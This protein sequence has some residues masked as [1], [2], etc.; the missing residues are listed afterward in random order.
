MH[1]PLAN[2]APFVESGVRRQLMIAACACGR[3]DSRSVGD[4][5]AWSLTLTTSARQQPDAEISST[6]E[7]LATRGQ[8]LSGDGAVASGSSASASTRDRCS[9]RQASNGPSV[10]MTGSVMR[11]G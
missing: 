6:V 10:S 3:L 4:S 7:L 2:G 11:I 9:A 1:L 8:L 5:P